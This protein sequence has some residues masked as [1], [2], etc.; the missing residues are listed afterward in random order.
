MK[1]TELMQKL[2]EIV[3][4]KGP[5]VTVAVLRGTFDKMTSRQ[6]YFWDTLKADGIKVASYGD[7]SVIKIGYSEDY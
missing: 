5:D 4:E 1:A 7:S 6:E 3:V 2:G